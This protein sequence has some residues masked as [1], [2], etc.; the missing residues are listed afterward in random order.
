MATHTEFKVAVTVDSLEEPERQPCSELLAICQLLDA[1]ALAR[2]PAE[3]YPSIEPIRSASVHD[4][5]CFLNINIACDP[6]DQ[7]S[8][9]GIQIRCQESVADQIDALLRQIHSR[10]EVETALL[11]GNLG[12]SDA[13]EVA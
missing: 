1:P 10:S 9:V 2:S 8:V 12:L 6:T 3:L 11:R 13:A 4:P 7:M 5:S